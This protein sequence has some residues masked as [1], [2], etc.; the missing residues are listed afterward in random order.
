[1]N[2]DAI[3]P[4]S[5]WRKALLDSEAIYEVVS[6]SGE[7]VTVEVLSAP[8]LPRG[9]LIRLTTSALSAME[10]VQPHYAPGR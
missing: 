7:H 3:V 1:M 10:P 5:W 9:Y 6:V 4:G 2:G 8:G